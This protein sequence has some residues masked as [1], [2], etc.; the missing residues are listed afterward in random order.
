MVFPLPTSFAS[1]T[2]TP[3]FWYDRLL[4]LLTLSHFIGCAGARNSQ[5][6][7][8]TR[9]PRTP[10]LD[11]IASLKFSAVRTCPSLTKR[12]T[13]ALIVAALRSQ[14]PLPP[15]GS[16]K[17]THLT[18]IPVDFCIKGQAASIAALFNNLHYLDENMLL[19]FLGVHFSD[20]E[21]YAP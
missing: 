18:I 20:Y 19:L 10:L 2:V 7:T 6:T 11:K 12:R 5:F 21:E 1:Q 14:E 15:C 13:C 3:V 8:A 9:T 16:V 17:S 4:I